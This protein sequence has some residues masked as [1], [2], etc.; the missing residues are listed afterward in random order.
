MLA[1]DDERSYGGG[2]EGIRGY[3]ED[4]LNM[5][6]GFRQDPRGLTEVG[7]CIV[8]DVHFT[9]RIKGTDNEMALDYSQV[10]LIEDG[11]ITRVKEFLEHDD[12]LAYAEG[13]ERGSS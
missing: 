2:L 4:W 3:F 6:D 9:A 1:A 10:S 7:D 8:A 12:A 5:V 11:K 13:S